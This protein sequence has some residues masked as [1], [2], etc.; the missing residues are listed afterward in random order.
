MK[1]LNIRSRDGELLV[2]A[3]AS[4][5]QRLEDNYYVDPACI[6]DSRFV[7]S[8]RVYL[9]P[10]KGKSFWVDLKTDRGW[11]NDICWVYPEPG[12]GY[13]HIAGWYGF[14]PEHE[15]YEIMS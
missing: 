1:K 4:Q 12:P 5:W 7:V 14:Y 15:Q 6:D 8:Q 13:R 10:A 2:S 11:L 9:C 3:E